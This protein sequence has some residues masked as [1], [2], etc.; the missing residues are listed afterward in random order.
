MKRMELQAFCQLYYCNAS[1]ELDG[2]QWVKIYEPLGVKLP[3]TAVPYC[4]YLNSIIF[5]DHELGGKELLRIEHH[6]LLFPETLILLDNGLWYEVA[7]ASCR[8]IAGEWTMVWSARKNT[9]RAR[10]MNRGFRH[11]LE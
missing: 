9:R 3:E 8:Y 1:Y 6:A 2:R 7:S 11:Y 10:M 5:Y 4:C